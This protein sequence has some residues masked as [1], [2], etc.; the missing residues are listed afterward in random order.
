M[1]CILTTRVEVLDETSGV[2]R[3][4]MFRL[5]TLERST[6]LRRELNG[7]SRVEP[8]V[9]A[10]LVVGIARVELDAVKLATGVIVVGGLHLVDTA[11]VE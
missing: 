3:L 7:V 8:A 6:P 10:M 11:V 5:A 4:E 2:S 1:L 9:E